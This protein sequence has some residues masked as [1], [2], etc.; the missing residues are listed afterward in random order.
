MRTEAAV[1][2][3]TAVVVVR[4]K[5]ESHA[6]VVVIRTVAVVALRFVAARWGEII[7]G[8]VQR[9]AQKLMP[10]LSLHACA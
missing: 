1:A 7:G 8:W 3:A 6:L 10:H 9:L 5:M 2:A 4:G